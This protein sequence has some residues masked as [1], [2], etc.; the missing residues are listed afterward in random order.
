[1][2]PIYLDTPEYTVEVWD[3]NDVFVADI[4]KLIAT[5][6]RI[7][8]KI[9]DVDDVSFSI[10]LVQFENL[11]ASIGARPISIIEPYRTDIKIRRNDEYLI[12]AHVVRTGV[13]FNAQETN[14]VEIQCTGYLN[15]FK[16]RIISTSYQNMTYAQIARTLITDSQSAYNYVTNDKFVT[17]ITGWQNV[18]GGYIIWDG[19][20]G[21]QAVGSLFAS[22]NTG[23]NTYGGARWANTMQAGLQYTATFWLKA[24]SPGGNVFVRT[25]ATA[26][27]TT[28][29]VSDTNWHQYTFTW[30][31]AADSGYFDIKMDTSTNFWI[32]EVKLSDNIDA[33]IR[34]DFGVTM[35]TD[36]ASPYQDSTRVRSYDLQNIKDA[37]I[38]L[39]KLDNDNFDFKFDAN[40]V[41]TTYP[42]LG[43]D[44]PEIELVYPQNITSMTTTRD[45]QTLYNKIFGVGSGIGDERLQVELM[46]NDS[47]LT[48]RTR[49]TTELYNSVE[50]MSTL[51]SNTTGALIEQ[52]DM[53]DTISVVVS[54]NTLD[55]N[56][57]QLGDA[58]Y[59]RVDGSSYVDYINGMYR[60]VELD[61]DVSID[62]EESVTLTLQ[63]WS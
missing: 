52:K 3:I 48:Y 28:Y 36:Y 1:M 41:F 44:K 43:S 32:D 61:I 39:T 33:P 5:S 60:I 55:L 4:S 16:D 29:A 54:N 37:I 35:G 30:T 7:S 20:V 50:V 23:P 40:K 51:V 8:Q 31:Q 42:R 56:Y 34:R 11:C 27:T 58:I 19:T 13:N 22:V 47:T 9:N 21:H 46:D 57:V 18:D 59:L 24:A 12:G 10:D 15:H 45:A 49:E 62:I 17:D 14:K 63:K 38:N 25:T 26:P 6:L 2:Q 53:Y